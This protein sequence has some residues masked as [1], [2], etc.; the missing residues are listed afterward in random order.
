M[1]SA[2]K[3]HL[4]CPVILHWVAEC[5]WWQAGTHRHLSIHA[6]RHQGSTALAM[7][8]CVNKLQWP[9]FSSRSFIVSGLTFRSL[10]HFE[11]IFVVGVRKCS[12]FILLQVAD[13][14]SQHHLLT[15]NRIAIRPSNP[16]PGHTHQGNQ[17]WKRHV[18]PNVH[19]STV[20]NSQDMEAT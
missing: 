4:K 14:F 18:R 9:M 13:Q 2:L 7:L 1:E 17:I 10:I 12:S 20:Y 3:K 8:G 6:Y 11:F 15:G 19:R 5:I 16:T